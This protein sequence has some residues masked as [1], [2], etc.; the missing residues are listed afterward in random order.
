MTVMQTFS[1]GR[2]EKTVSMH[3]PRQ[4]LL[5]ILWVSFRR[6]GLKLIEA[7]EP[8]TVIARNVQ[9]SCEVQLQI[10]QIHFSTAFS[11]LKF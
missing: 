5:A 1:Q 11:N 8:E 10:E 2:H 4:V 7:G 9:I 6:S 3:G